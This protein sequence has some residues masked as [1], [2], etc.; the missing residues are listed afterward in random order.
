MN[1]KVVQSIADL[2][3]WLFELSK[4]MSAGGDKINEIYLVPIGAK[5]QIAKKG[6]VQTAVF[7][8][9][10]PIREPDGQFSFEEPGMLYVSVSIPDSKPRYRRIYVAGFEVKIAKEHQRRVHDWTQ[11][12]GVTSPP[13]TA[14]TS[15]RLILAE[16]GG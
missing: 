2:R 1:K 3:M 11:L 12:T 5:F 8:G 16:T 7:A 6:K 4:G 9:A 15:R 13:P 14:E 10:R